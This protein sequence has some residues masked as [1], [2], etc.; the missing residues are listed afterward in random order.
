MVLALICAAPY[1]PLLLHWAGSGGA[2]Q[3][4]LEEGT[5][6]EVGARTPQAAELLG[7]LTLDA[8]GVDLP[9]RVVL[10][11][12]GLIWAFRTR[13][14]RTLAAVSAVFLVLAVASSLLNS[15][16][17]IRQIY[18]ATYPWSVPYR[19]LTFASITLALLAGGGSV[20]LAALWAGWLAHLRGVATRR[21]LSRTGRLLVVTW[22]LLSTLAIVTL[23]TP[24]SGRTPGNFTDADA[25]AMTWLRANAEPGA[26]LANDTFADAGI[27]APY[28]AGVPILF[29]R[30]SGDPETVEAG[31]LVLTNIA[32]L[33]EVPDAAA[34]AC[35]LNVRY[36]YRGAQDSNWQAR[37]FP[38]LQELRASRA[39]QEVFNLGEASVFRTQL[40]CAH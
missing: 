29:Y 35:K 20:W 30:A 4:G 6:L 11:A 31:N 19:H 22:A 7:L 15:L 18:A 17:V 32:R 36:V 25:A 37:S 10:I 9:V 34:A 33:D 13:T 16:P 39:L 12:L 23:L 26:V 28:K 5:A 38:A 1:L 40:N 8:L 3:V 24:A 2:Y 27:W 21:R 14:G